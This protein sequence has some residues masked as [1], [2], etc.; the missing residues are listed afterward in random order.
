MK[1][2]L[3]VFVI[4]VVLF[5]SACGTR[6]LSSSRS[7]PKDIQFAFNGNWQLIFSSEGNGLNG[8]IVAINPTQSNATMVSISNNSY[9]IGGSTALWQ[10]IQKVTPDAY[11]ANALTSACND[12]LI[13]NTATI[14]IVSSEEIRLVGKTIKGDDLLQRWRRVKEHGVNAR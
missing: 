4:N 13:Y 5:I 11:S 10:N 1:C 9:C 12:S 14:E 2:L 3:V 6:D 8:S 7:E